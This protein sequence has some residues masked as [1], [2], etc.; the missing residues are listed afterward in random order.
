MDIIDAVISRAREAREIISRARQVNCSDSAVVWSDEAVAFLDSVDKFDALVTPDFARVLIHVSSFATTPESVTKWCNLVFRSTYSRVQ[1]ESS[2]RADRLVELGIV[3]ILCE[4]TIV[5]AD[6]SAATISWLFAV[7][8]FVTNSPSARD[9]FVTEDGLLAL[10]R[11]AVNIPDRSQN[12]MS[13]IKFNGIIFDLIH[14]NVSEGKQSVVDPAKVEMIRSSPHLAPE[15][16]R[17]RR[18][19][20]SDSAF[21]RAVARYCQ[22]LSLSDH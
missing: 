13:L 20:R 18:S 17:I 16:L 7:T 22:I 8:V 12:P 6:V 15:I 9:L 5:A 21:G 11:M 10:A 4:M 2:I 14:V 3:P 1:N 19:V